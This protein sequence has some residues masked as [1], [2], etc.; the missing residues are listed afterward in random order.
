MPTKH[1]WSI[2]ASSYLEWV[3]FPFFMPRGRRSH[4][5]FYLVTSGRGEVHG[6][7]CIQ[8]AQS[9]NVS[10][11]KGLETWSTSIF[12]LNIS[13]I[14]PDQV[15]IAVPFPY[16]FPLM[17]L[18]PASSVST[19]RQTGTGLNILVYSTFYRVTLV[20]VIGATQFLLGYFSS[21]YPWLSRRIVAPFFIAYN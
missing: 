10:K 20:I 7:D 4:R 5:L 1:V 8:Q 11:P 2:R 19:L 14:A 15:K 18:A 3:Q 9:Q 21:L 17:S 16:L 13:V 6:S 12:L